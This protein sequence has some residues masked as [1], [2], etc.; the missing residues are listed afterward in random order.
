MSSRTARS[1]SSYSKHNDEMS[2]T[3]SLH[4]V[5]DD[6]S[7]TSSKAVHHHSTSPRPTSSLKTNKTSPVPPSLLSQHLNNKGVK[8]LN[9]GNYRKA[10]HLFV[11]AIKTYKEDEEE[12]ECT[13]R[14]CS[15]SA[16]VRYSL[17]HDAQ[18]S[19]VDTS[20]SDDYVHRRGI[21]IHPKAMGHSMGPGLLQIATLNLAIAKHLICLECPKSDR[22]EQARKYQKAASLYEMAFKWHVGQS[23][24]QSTVNITFFLII[25]N[26]LSQIHRENQNAAKQSMC[27]FH[28]QSAL[29]TLMTAADESEMYQSL[30]L[31]G[32]FRTAFTQ[33]SCAS[34]A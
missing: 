20:E 12:V 2:S 13:C 27:R 6:A 15:V 33:I 28:L 5:C 10:T 18:H 26:N 9:Y 31:D 16:S 29:L 24:D 19:H 25:V 11:Q 22:K 3:C 7:Q 8:A 21:S 30:N 14:H 1:I 34:A 17:E 4:G 32:F 23:H